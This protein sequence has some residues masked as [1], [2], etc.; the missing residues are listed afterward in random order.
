[1]NQYYFSEWLTSNNASSL[2]IH[3]YTIPLSTEENRYSLGGQISYELSKRNN[4]QTIV[5]FEQYLA[6][7]SEINSWDKYEYIKYEARPICLDKAYERKLLERLVKKE[8]EQ[9][10][11]LTHVMDRGAFRLKRTKPINT[12]ELL[13]YPA[14]QINVEVGENGEIFVGFDYIHRF[15]YRDNLLKLL[16]LNESFILKG[17]SVVDVNNPKTHEYEFLEIAPYKAGD[18]SPYLKESVINYYGRK[19]EPKKLV[20]VDAASMIVHVKNKAGAIFP[21]L[22]HL[23]KLSCSF[24]SLPT[25][26]SKIASKAIKMKPSEKMQE[27]FK[28]THEIL[29]KLP[30]L[31]FPKENVRAVN[32]GYEVKNAN[33]PLLRFGNECTTSKLN[34]GL[35]KG[36]IYKGK[37]A[38]VSFFVDPLLQKNENMRANV[39]DFI[40]LLTQESSKMGVN[41]IVSGKPREL[42]GQLEQNFLSS[43]DLGYKLKSIAKYFNGTVVVIASEQ[44]INHA[45]KIVKREFGGKQDI[46][47]QFV[48]FSNAL[49]DR[50]KSLYTI[51]N[52]LLGIYVKSGLQ[53]WVLGENLNSDCFIGLDVSHEDG[54]HASGII[55]IIGKDGTMI[56]QKS[57]STNEA[58]ERISMGT[59]EEIL[60]DTIHSYKERYGETPMHITFH[61]DGFCREDLVFIAEKLSRMGIAFDYVEVLKNVNR[62]MATY[63]NGKWI[64]E[65]SMYYKKD[66]MGYLC[67]TSPKE[68]VGMAR[69]V[70]VV[71]KTNQ[72]DF[73]QIMSD[74][75]KLSYMHIHSMLKTRLP[76]TTHYADLSST[77]HN[78]GLLHPSTRHE[79]ALPFV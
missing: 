69:V 13:I 27:L 17:T 28:E 65:Q 63:D 10:S 49:L 40:K 43:A 14:I 53:P 46:V 12:E 70:K 20:G 47:T 7:F 50:S 39:G 4:Y 78:R 71:Q 9:R 16:N 61:R 23:L 68:F 73:D 33:A 18:E 24:D 5:F 2:L 59:I 51:Y 22:P 34:E 74:V 79:E 56:K 44:T 60:Y 52:I 36:G 77:F 58:G 64:T 55:Q 8:L 75:Y 72:L 45:Y 67:S 21:Y 31:N 38:H 41:L 1:M 3:L 30:M 42:R 32:L 26:L 57:L 25:H 62:R 76:I 29:Q 66:K 37:E 11:R 48:S 6:S 54:K 35:R 15:E 19:G